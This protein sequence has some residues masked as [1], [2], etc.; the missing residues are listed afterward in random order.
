MPIDLSLKISIPDRKRFRS[1]CHTLNFAL[2]PLI[3]SYLTVDPKRTM[4]EQ[5]ELLADPSYHGSRFVKSV[6]IKRFVPEDEDPADD[7][8]I[9]HALS[10]IREAL[11]PAL[12]SLKNLQTV[13]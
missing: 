2:E 12:S 10:V 11:A 1:A 9:V 4:L 5:L 6:K 13:K 3:L 8:E 7:R